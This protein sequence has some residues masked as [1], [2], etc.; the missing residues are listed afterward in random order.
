MKNRVEES[1]PDLE[2]NK[3][4]SE[5]RLKQIFSLDELKTA[6][7]RYAD[8]IQ[9][10][11]PR[12]YQVLISH[13]PEIISETQIQIQLS[14]E[15][16]KKDMQEKIQAALLGF[17]KEELNNY[18]INLVIKITEDLKTKD[19]IY[20]ESDK[21]KYLSEKNPELEMLK[22]KFNLDFE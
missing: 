3:N 15:S 4:I 19:L 2:S 9:S 13:I 6:W 22:K 17:L 10:E 1:K 16:Q 7:L 14:S 21:F 12:M 11:L 20:T 8:K 5:N 18:S